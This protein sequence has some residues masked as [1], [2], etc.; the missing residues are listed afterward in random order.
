LKEVAFEKDKANIGLKRFEKK[1]FK[2]ISKSIKEM[3]ADGKIRKGH[4]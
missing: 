1:R 2:E 4:E 3:C